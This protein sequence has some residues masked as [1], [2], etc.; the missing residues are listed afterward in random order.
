[1]NHSSIGGNIVCIKGEKNLSKTKWGKNKKKETE[2]K[3][4]EKNPKLNAKKRRIQ[5]VELFKGVH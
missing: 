1:M 3:K 5:S 2:E 4:T